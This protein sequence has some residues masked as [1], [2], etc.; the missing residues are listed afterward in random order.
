MKNVGLLVSLE[1]L[2]RRIPDLERGCDN[3]TAYFDNRWKL[4]G[5]GRLQSCSDGFSIER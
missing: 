3:D 2:K 5:T 4:E 1:R